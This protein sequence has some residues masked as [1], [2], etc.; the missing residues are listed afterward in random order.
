MEKK[1]IIESDVSVLELDKGLFEGLP[2][3]K[4]FRIRI[5]RL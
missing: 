1:S 2:L 5:K 4:S 3:N